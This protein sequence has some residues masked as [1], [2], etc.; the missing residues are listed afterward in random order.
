EGALGTDDSDKEWLVADSLSGRVY[1]SYTAFVEDPVSHATLSRIMFASADSNVVTWTTP[2]QVSLDTQTENGFVQGSRPVVD[3]DG[4][5]YVVYFLI[6][7]GFADYYRIRRSD[8]QGASFGVPVTAESLYTNFGTGPPG[9]NRE[10]S[11]DFPGIGVDRSHGPH[12]GRVYLSWAE[13]IN[14]LDEV[15]DIGFSGNKS[16]LEPND[17]AAGA[18]PAVI[19]QTLRGTVSSAADFD[20]YAV[21]LTQ[22]QHVVIDADSSEALAQNQLGCVLRLLAGDRVTA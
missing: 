18:T 7:Q 21:A 1:L 9:F 15:F 14:W 4:H 16:E 5:V 17:N 11:V 10:I 13:S 19:G 6:G 20:Y 12:R 8:N 2:R 3:G 22:G